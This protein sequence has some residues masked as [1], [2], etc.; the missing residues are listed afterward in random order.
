M[1]A[2]VTKFINTFLWA[3]GFGMVGCWL[4]VHLYHVVLGY[5]VGMVCRLYIL[6]VVNSSVSLSSPVSGSMFGWAIFISLILLMSFICYIRTIWQLLINQYII[7]GNVVILVIVSMCCV[8]LYNVF[9]I[10]WDMFWNSCYSLLFSVF[11][12]TNVLFTLFCSS[13]SFSVEL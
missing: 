2:L 10:F 3:F 7:T 4:L 13:S 12:V 8:L 11:S 1:I 6:L 5:F 9:G